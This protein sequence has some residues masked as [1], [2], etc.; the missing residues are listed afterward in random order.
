MCGSPELAVTRQ[1]MWCFV[2]DP[3]LTGYRVRKF[4][5]DWLCLITYEGRE[6]S[7]SFEGTYTG[8]HDDA[9]QFREPSVSEQSNVVMR[10]ACTL[11][12]HKAMRL[13]NLHK[14]INNSLSW[15][16]LPSL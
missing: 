8:T 9:C 15:Q 10:F 2:S 11:M 6:D 3:N 14:K 16:K 13:T 7:S 5:T 1:L 12:G 4:V